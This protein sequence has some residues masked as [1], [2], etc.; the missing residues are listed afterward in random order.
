MDREAWCAAIHGV[1]K[2]RTW[3]SDW[4]DLKGKLLF[5]NDSY[6]PGNLQ[7]PVHYVIVQNTKRNQNW[8]EVCLGS[9]IN[10][11][12]FTFSQFRQRLALL[13]LNLN[14]FVC[15]MV[16]QLFLFVLFQ[17][18]GLLTLEKLQSFEYERG[19]KSKMYLLNMVC[20]C[21]QPRWAAHVLRFLTTKYTYQIYEG[22]N[23]QVYI[24]SNC[25]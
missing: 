9:G 1:A 3:L 2:S 21:S 14:D 16:F 8:S 13:F 12:T 22:G 18:C 17:A 4:S 10:I 5:D 19:K 24:S 15:F 11:F 25:G 7:K 6:I 20:L 23:H